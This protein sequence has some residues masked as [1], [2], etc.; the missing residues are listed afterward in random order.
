MSRIN[1]Y[2]ETQTIL[3]IHEKSFNDV[4]WIGIQNI[5]VFDK[6]N[7]IKEMKQI[8][9]DNGYGGAEINIDLVVVGDNWWLE[10]GE[11]DG[12]E[13]WKFKTIPTKP[14]EKLTYSEIDQEW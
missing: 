8:N 6:E 11:Y 12:A 13:W 3:K 2:K 7:F 5:A 1:L 10:R 4:K 14:K 9:Y